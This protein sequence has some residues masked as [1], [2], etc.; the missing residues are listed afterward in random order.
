MSDVAVVEIGWCLDIA[1]CGLVFDAPLG[2]MQQTPGLQPSGNETCTPVFYSAV[3]HT[4]PPAAS[5][6][7]RVHSLPQSAIIFLEMLSKIN[8]NPLA[9]GGVCPVKSI[10]LSPSHP[11]HI[12]L[13]RPRLEPSPGS[14]TTQNLPGTNPL[15]HILSPLPSRHHAWRK[16]RPKA[17]Q[18]TR[19]TC[20]EHVGPS[21][22]SFRL[23]SSPEMR[24]CP[25]LPVPTRQNMSAQ[26]QG[27]GGR[28]SYCPNE[29]PPHIL[30]SA[31]PQVLRG[32]GPA[33]PRDHRSRAQCVPRPSMFSSTACSG[34]SVSPSP[35]RP[36]AP[37]VLI[38]C[39]SPSPAWPKPCASL[40]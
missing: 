15:H 22:N 32:P 5:S 3:A 28:C 27:R 31:N 11:S 37:R 12:P 39:P 30:F 19:G 2:D 6:T 4:L 36:R 9:H 35:A 16:Q 25:C 10:L 40:S 17:D 34:L 23:L 29:Q 13:C 38:L 24:P 21:V 26:S 7:R 1:A 33:Y 8:K 14:P 20:A 18:K